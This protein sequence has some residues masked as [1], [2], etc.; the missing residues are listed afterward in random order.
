MVADKF[1]C[2]WKWEGVD[3]VGAWVVVSMI[4]SRQVRQGRMESVED[5]YKKESDARS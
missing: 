3:L 5:R 1:P 4:G 2:V